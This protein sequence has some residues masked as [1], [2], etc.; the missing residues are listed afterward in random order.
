M[1]TKFGY[2]VHYRASRSRLRLLLRLKVSRPRALL[3]VA[4]RKEAMSS[5]VLRVINH[6]WVL[7][8]HRGRWSFNR[9]CRA[10]ALSRTTPIRLSRGQP[11]L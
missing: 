7:N 6:D 4:Y 5:T 2:T 3:P 1:Q 11:K 8:G 9:T 10:H